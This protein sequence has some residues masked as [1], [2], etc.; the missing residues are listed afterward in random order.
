MNCLWLV[1]TMILLNI[2]KLKKGFGQ[3]IKCEIMKK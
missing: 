3:E 2:N 1:V